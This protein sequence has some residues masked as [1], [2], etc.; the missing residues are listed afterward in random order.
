MRVYFAHPMV[1]F[2]TEQERG[3]ESLIR[4][5]FPDC[6]ILNPKN[7]QPIRPEDRGVEW[8]HRIIDTCDVF[9]FSRFKGRITAGVGGEIE[10]AQGKGL[11]VFEVRD[12]EVT[13]FS[14]S[15]S[16]MTLEETRAFYKGLKVTRQ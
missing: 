3:Q 16:Y 1:T 9:V 8:F 14:G 12:G 4:K 15:I 7:S 6:M 13:P 10:Y 2:D 5:A 11:Q